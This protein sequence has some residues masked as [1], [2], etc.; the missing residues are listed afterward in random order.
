VNA[1]ARGRGLGHDSINQW[2]AVKRRCERLGVPSTCPTCEG[3]GHVF[4][5]PAAHVSLTL[6]WLHPRKGCSRGLEVTRLQQDDMPAVFAFLRGA[7]QRNAERFGRIP[8][9][10]P[11]VVAA[12]PALDQGPCTVCG[13]PWREHGTY[14]VCESHNY[15]PV[16][17]VGGND[18]R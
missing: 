13:K 11:V 4:T 14:P 2:I 7:A 16:S 15:T 3:H 9:G 5:E 1:W 10:V 12:N 6:W 17:G 8:A 18:G